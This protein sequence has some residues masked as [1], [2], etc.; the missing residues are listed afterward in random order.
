MIG[1]LRKNVVLGTLLGGIA[2]VLG[3]AFIMNYIDAIEALVAGLVVA[4]W[5]ARWQWV[6]QRRQQ[7]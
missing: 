1:F 5:F 4:C 6:R 7:K 3:G 2:F